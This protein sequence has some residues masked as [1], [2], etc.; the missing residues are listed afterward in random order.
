[1]VAVSKPWHLWLLFFFLSSSPRPGSHSSFT[2]LY[3]NEQVMS[4]SDAVRQA[5]K[6]P[7]KPKQHNWPRFQSVHHLPRLGSSPVI[8]FVCTRLWTEEGIQH[9]EAIQERL[10][11]SSTWNS[12]LYTVLLISACNPLFP[13]REYVWQSHRTEP[14]TLR[15]WD[16]QPPGVGVEPRKLGL[17]WKTENRIS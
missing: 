15:S 12:V 8:F 4:Q 13:W 3:P 10:F 7:L 9:K 2:Y 14:L 6:S 16:P 5:S 17:E 1:M 11:L